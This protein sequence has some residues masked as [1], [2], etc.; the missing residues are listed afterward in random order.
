MVAIRLILC[1]LICL[2]STIAE[3]P[4]LFNALDCRN[5]TKVEYGEIETLCPEKTQQKGFQSGIL[6]LQ[7]IYHKKVKAKVCSRVRTEQIF[8]CG[9]YSHIKYLQPPTFEEKHP[10]TVD[11]CQ[12]M[13]DTQQYISDDGKAH[14]I[15][16]NEEI[17]L[18]YVSHGVMRPKGDNN[19]YCEG[20]TLTIGQELHQSVL[21]LV[22][23]KIQ[24]EEV[25]IQYHLDSSKVIDL[26]NH[27]ELSNQCHGSY[28]CITNGKTYVISPP[29]DQCEMAIIR[30]SE[31]TETRVL[32]ENGYETL[33]VSSDDKIALVKK[34]MLAPTHNCHQ[35]GAIYGTNI[36]SLNVG[37]LKTSGPRTMDTVEGDHINMNIIIK[38][39]EEYLEAKLDKDIQH[40]L[41]HVMRKTCDQLVSNFGS[42]E[43]SPFR[44]N[45]VIKVLGDVFMHITCQPVQVMVDLDARQ[46]FISSSCYSDYLPVKTMNNEQVL[47]SSRLHLIKGLDTTD[48]LLMIPCNPLKTPKF[49]S[50]D[51][52]VYHMTPSIQPANL[53][54][55]KFSDD[56]N[57]Y[58]VS[59]KLILEDMGKAKVYTDEE[60]RQFMDLIH[61][62][63]FKSQVTTRLVHDFCVDNSCTGTYASH[64]NMLSL[65]GARDEMLGALSHLKNHIL[66][67]L[68]T[69][70]NACSI[71]VVCIYVGIICQRLFL[72]LQW[73]CSGDREKRRLM[74]I[75]LN[76]PN[77]PL[78]E[79]P[80]PGISQS[81]GLCRK[82]DVERHCEEYLRKLYVDESE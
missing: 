73:C 77:Y 4:V 49:I 21:I 43:R 61:E 56:M 25:D 19:A 52:H 51:R 71:F 48:Q 2:N 46:D 82:E 50:V 54:I 78:V 72:S 58:M 37:T 34:R 55:A 22:A 12:K 23:E 69:I 70:G 66:W 60:M 15:S 31:F 65:T 74:D 63:R 6:L 26:S 18:S 17:D 44:A 13:I 80:K 8:I 35:I 39:T 29:K 28:S 5:P 42:T 81:Q 3:K 11:D 27:I 59:D 76:R 10:M 7:R 9:A 41:K 32:T 79:Q 62:G 68:T 38:A 20:V 14:A 47:I 75:V 64:G 24:L 1:M 40:S 36:D 33:L 67:Y 30:S 16:V 53:T 45:S 57:R